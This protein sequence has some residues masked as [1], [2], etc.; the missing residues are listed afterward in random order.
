MSNQDPKRLA[1]SIQATKQYVTDQLK[2]FA[3]LVDEVL[4]DL[5]EAKDIDQVELIRACFDFGV[6]HHVVNKR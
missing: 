2:D 4:A 1:L 5:D 6:R 3:E